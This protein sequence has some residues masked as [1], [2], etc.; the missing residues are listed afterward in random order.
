[1]HF[2]KKKN[3][4]FSLYCFPFFWE[5]PLFFFFFQIIEIDSERRRFLVS[6]K[7]SD[8]YPEKEGEEKDNSNATFGIDLLDGRIQERDEILENFQNMPGTVV[9]TITANSS[10]PG[11]I[12]ASDVAGLP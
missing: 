10:C 4:V 12:S 7:P 8:C 11:F 9:F 6:L 1:M 3:C 2:K 5:H